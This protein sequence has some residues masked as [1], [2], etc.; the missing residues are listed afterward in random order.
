MSTTANGGHRLPYEVIEGGSGPYLFLVHGMLSSR[1]QWRPNLE[2]LCRH[3]R[4][5]LFDLW[6]H[7]DAPCPLD[8]ESYQVS[9]IIGEFETVRQELGAQRVLLCGQ[10]LGACFTLR[11]SFEHPERVI[12]QMFTNSMSALSP[13]GAFGDPAQRQARAA[14]IEAE[15][16]PAL[17]KLPFHPRHARRLPPQVRDELIEA[18]DGV[19]PRAFARLS[20]IT[21]PQLSVAAELHR[22]ACPTLLVNGVWEKT[23]Q[24]LRDIAVRDIPG[25]E[26][27]DLQAGHA[28]NL[29]NIEAFNQVA[30]DFLGRMA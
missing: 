9:T 27:A 29:E 20:T 5:V 6:G 7:G 22:I 15:G 14:L 17:A 4:P 18:A 21:G 8:D 28:V 13:P 3:A 19:D 11:Y 2:A 24:P 12:G 1:R 10:S 26:V 16:A 30:A 23:F 25:C